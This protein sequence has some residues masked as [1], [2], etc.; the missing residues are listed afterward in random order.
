M[1]ITRI[2]DWT[3]IGGIVNS[4]RSEAIKSRE[5]ALKRMGL[6]AEKIA[7]GHI[8]A[9]DLK[10]SPLSIKYK[11]QKVRQGM[12]EN[13]LVATSSYFQQITSW[14]SDGT[15]YVGVKKMARNKEGQE[16][17]NIAA[18]HEYGS[19][20]ANIPPRP[21]WKPTLGETKDAILKNKFYYSPAH[22]FHE[23]LT[24]F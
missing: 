13:I 17:A 2:G 20:V 11:A 14:T 19:T 23:R 9:Q 16:L 5:I 3:R 10:W 4:L 1:G 15:V 24:R 18:V 8:S 6:T 12:S 7:K 22:I 21:L